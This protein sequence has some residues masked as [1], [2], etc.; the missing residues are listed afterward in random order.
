VNSDGDIR[1][2]R[3]RQS[4]VEVLVG[5]STVAIAFAAFG[6]TAELILGAVALVGIALTLER[7]VPAQSTGNIG[8]Q[9]L[10]P[11]EPESARPEPQA[12]VR[13]DTAIADATSA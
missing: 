13:F 9:P 2:G 11:E 1:F 12:T 7:D 3:W 10:R 5:A 6:A 4:I 8:P